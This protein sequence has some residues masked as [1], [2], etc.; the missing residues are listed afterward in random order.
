MKNGNGDVGD[1]SS[2]AREVLIKQLHTDIEEHALKDLED[3]FLA[4][5]LSICGIVDNGQCP[6]DITA[7][8][9]KNENI[10]EAKNNAGNA[11][12]TENGQH[13]IF[14]RRLKE[15]LKNF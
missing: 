15:E 9:P 10:V 6:E 7:D 2:A 12:A 4:R 3:K 8:Y 5:D 11:E 13:R 14:P 1:S